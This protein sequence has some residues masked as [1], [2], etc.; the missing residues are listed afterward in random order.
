MTAASHPR[1]NVPWSLWLIVSRM[2]F[3]S[4]K[5]YVGS[6]RARIRKRER[7]GNTAS[8]LVADDTVGDGAK[9]RRATGKVDVGR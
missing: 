7:C 3:G 2:C 6:N 9:W 5:V 8:F 1:A 4:V